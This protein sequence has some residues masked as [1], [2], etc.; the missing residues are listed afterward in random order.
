MGKIWRRF[1]I[2]S[3][4]LVSARILCARS[5]SFHLV[6]SCVPWRSESIIDGK[7]KLDIY[8]LGGG[9]NIRKIWERYYAEVCAARSVIIAEYLVII[10][11][12]VC[13]V[14]SPCGL[15][16]LSIRSIVA[17]FY[18]DVQPREKSWNHCMTQK[19]SILGTRK[20]VSCGHWACYDCVLV[21]QA[22]AFVFSLWLR[23][24]RV[25][26]VILDIFESRLRW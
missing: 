1:S 24:S 5:P 19:M 12:C 14:P 22:D 2:V 13:S 21:Y 7:Y 16:I 4:H 15:P 20:V 26:S 25:F 8:D 9:R 11:V 3:S 18:V 23:I 10:L 17:M 6:S